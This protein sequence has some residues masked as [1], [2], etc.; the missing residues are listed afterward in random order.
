MVGTL[1]IVNLLPG[2]QTLYAD[3][4]DDGIVAKKNIPPS[5]TRGEG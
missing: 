1:S 5:P 4:K 3:L 2:N